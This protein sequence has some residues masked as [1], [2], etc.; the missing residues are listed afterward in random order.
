MKFIICLQNFLRLSLFIFS[1]NSLF[2]FNLMAMQ[3]KHEDTESFSQRSETKEALPESV[4]LIAQDGHELIIPFEIAKYSDVL[5]KLAI[6]HYNHT[7][8]KIFPIKLNLPE[9]LLRIIEQF[10]TVESLNSYITK[11]E[12]KAVLDDSVKDLSFDESVLLSQALE[13]L[14]LDLN[15]IFKIL[16]DHLVAKF[17]NKANIET[18]IKNSTFSD[19]FK[20]A[21]AKTYFFD[22]VNL[23][24]YWDLKIQDR[25]TGGGIEYGRGKDWAKKMINNLVLDIGVDYG[26]SIQDLIEHKKLPQSAFDYIVHLK[27]V[28]NYFDRRVDEVIVVLDLES[29]KINSLAGLGN[30]ANYIKNLYNFP[31]E[32]KKF[33]FRVEDIN[34]AN[35]QLTTIQ[36][37]DFRSDLISLAELKNLNLNNNRIKLVESGAFSG[38]RNL[39]ALNLENNELEK[40]NL[41]NFSENKKLKILNLMGNKF[42]KEE[43]LKLTITNFI[44]NKNREPKLVIGFNKHIEAYI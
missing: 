23:A 19:Q 28:G 26:F 37:N 33:T 18:Y 35:N 36:H 14:N 13:Y 2:N 31:N 24:N 41:R 10:L 6:L 40:I 44:M 32:L 9:H 16:I 22:R 42:S 4:K 5:K 15:P 1:L 12:R 17:K 20:V 27:R 38:L 11:D 43:I 30:I 29:L 8:A 7:K 3:G 39:I 25:E 21:L 34:L